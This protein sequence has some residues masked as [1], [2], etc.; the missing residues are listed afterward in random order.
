MEETT[1]FRYFTIAYLTNV[2][3]RITGEKWKKKKLADTSPNSGSV[4]TEKNFSSGSILFGL[5]TNR[6]TICNHFHWHMWPDPLAPHYNKWLE[7][8]QKTDPSQSS[9]PTLM[10]LPSPRLA[11]CTD[12]KTKRFSLTK[13]EVKVNN[14]FSN[15]L[16]SLCKSPISLRR[17]P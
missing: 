1:Y 11:L 16:V 3:L 2:R 13:P 8:H 15:L 14:T 7:N 12:K 17:S 6:D 9:S 10:K 5:S 4:K